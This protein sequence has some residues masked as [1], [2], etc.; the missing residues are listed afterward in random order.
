M[1]IFFL[2]NLSHTLCDTTGIA[3]HEEAGPGLGFHTVWDLPTAQMQQAV[4][5]NLIWGF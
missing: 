2:Y 3:L 5:R 1:W 4:P